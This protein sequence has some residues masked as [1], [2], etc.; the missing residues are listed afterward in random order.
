LISSWLKATDGASSAGGGDF[1][2]MSTLELLDGCVDI[3]Q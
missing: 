1:D 2:G 3:M